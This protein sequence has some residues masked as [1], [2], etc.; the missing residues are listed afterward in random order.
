[1]EHLTLLHGALEVE[2]G[3]DSRKLKA[4]ATAR[5]QADKNHAIRNLGKTEAKALMVVIHR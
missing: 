4:G 2:V 5:Y 3:G 1:M